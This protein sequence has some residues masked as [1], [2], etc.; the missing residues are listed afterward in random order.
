MKLWLLRHARVLAAPGLCY[1]ATDLPADPGLVARMDRARTICSVGSSLRKA[2]G[3]RVR[4]P[5]ASLTVV[6]PQAS[7]LADLADVVSDELNVKQVRLVDASEAAEAQFGVT[8]RLGVNARAAGPRLGKDVQRAIKGSKT[9]D[10]SVADDGTVTSGGLALL[11]GEYTLEVVVADAGEA[12]TDRATGL[13]P[14]GGFVVLDT[15]VTDELAAEGLARD[16]VRAVQQAR[17]EA[18]L[19]V[20]DRIGLTVLG[21]DAVWAATVAHQQLIMDETLATQF[22]SAPRTDALPPEQGTWATVGDGRPVRIVVT[23]R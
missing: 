5:L 15:H 14:G 21:D 6:A 17:K 7:D 8:R 1:G 13:L 3:L 23:P 12:G 18:G 16:V 4:L 19:Q 10:W 22:G 20:G 9:G 11:E 2:A